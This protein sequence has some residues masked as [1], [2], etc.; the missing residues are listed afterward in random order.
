MPKYVKEI[1]HMYTIVFHLIFSV[2]IRLFSSILREMQCMHI[3]KCNLLK[4]YSRETLSIEILLTIWDDAETLTERSINQK[5]CCDNLW[6]DLRYHIT[7]ALIYVQQCKHSR[8][9]SLAYISY[10]N[11][12]YTLHTINLSQG[13]I[14]IWAIT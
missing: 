3:L 4:L 2:K 7:R 5:V 14:R 9:Q 12:I 8:Q 1:K 11:N 10:S 6:I 13:K